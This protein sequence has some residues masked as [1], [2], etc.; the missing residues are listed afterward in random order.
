MKR[1][2]KYK[3]Y[4]IKTKRFVEI[5]SQKKCR[6]KYREF[7]SREFTEVN[8][9]KSGFCEEPSEVGDGTVD[10]RPFNSR[11]VKCQLPLR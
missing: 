2:E 10:I 4:Q 3:R 8:Q 6:G 9:E 7:R 5:K 1:R 11:R